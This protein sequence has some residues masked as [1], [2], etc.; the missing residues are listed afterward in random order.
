MKE[1]QNV[2]FDIDV[3]QFLH[4]PQVPV[5]RWAQTIRHVLFICLG[6]GLE[7]LSGC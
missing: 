2:V 1:I 4:Y 7:P 5:L 3:L 6:D